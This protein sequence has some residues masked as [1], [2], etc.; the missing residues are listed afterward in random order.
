MFL[1]NRER[2]MGTGAP[3]AVAGYDFSDRTA[4]ISYCLPGS[5][6]PETVSLV[7]GEE[8]FLIPA[9][10][11]RCAE[12]DLWLFGK[13]AQE[14]VEKGEA[15]AVTD[16]LERA[17][18]RETVFL[19]G[20]PYDPVALLSLF[21]KRTL[22]LLNPILPLGRIRAFVFTVEEVTGPVIEALT[23][24]VSL[25]GL[26]GAKLYV[27][28]RAESFFYYNIS[29]PAELWV[30]DVLLCDFSGP[31]LKTFLFTLNRRTTPVAA[32]VEEA[33]FPHVRRPEDARSG[34]EDGRRRER[35][36]KLD[37]YFADAVGQLMKD[38]TVSTVYLI[39][40]GFQ[41]EWY[42]ESLKLLCQGRRVF[43]G[44]NLYSKGACYAAKERLSGSRLSA[45]YAFLGRDMIRANVGMHVLRRGQDAY[46]ALLDAGTNW[47]EAKK[48]CE[49][50][51]EEE[52]SFSL[53]ITPLNGKEVREVL[54]SLNGLAKRPPRMTRIRMRV[55]MTDVSTVR[56][57]MEDLGFGEFYPATHQ[58]WEETFSLA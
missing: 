49:F 23:Q 2:E 54:V 42:Q 16:L 45:D 12:R 7:A 8:Q 40:E 36:E 6:Q 14:S 18:R 21:L 26:K 58:F 5:G 3:G 46:L 51:L 53:R 38:R 35:L 32:F 30:H 20:Q 11:A 39:G 55:D 22:S 28:G 19:D 29:Q 9:L 50:L 24:S 41:G 43:L 17:V 10:L 27:I 33:S 31:C 4:Q 48:E 15:A 44:N 57:N 34:E 47:Y 37:R 56:I 1:G 52:N 25:L 13:E